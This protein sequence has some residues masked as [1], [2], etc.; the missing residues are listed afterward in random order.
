MKKLKV[1]VREV[2]AIVNGHQTDIKNIITEWVDIN[3]EEHGHKIEGS[4][5]LRI[6]WWGITKAAVGNIADA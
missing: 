3:L 6:W 1:N 2:E 5:K 4:R